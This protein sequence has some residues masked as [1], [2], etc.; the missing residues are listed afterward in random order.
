MKTFSLKKEEIKKEWILIDAK[1]AVLGRLAAFSANVLRGKNKPNYTPNQDCGD[2]LIIINADHI[3]LTV[4]KVK[5]KI[6]YRHTG[7]PGGIKETNPEK[8]KSK[9]K[10]NEIIKLAIKRM[11]P[12]GPLGKKQ[13]SNGKIDSGEKHSHEAQQPTKGD[14][15]KLNVKNFKR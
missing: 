15:I 12:S 8:M 14:F 4:K 11:I 2:N 1:D 10:S 6:Y 13:L 9:D 5:D 7:Y 3:H